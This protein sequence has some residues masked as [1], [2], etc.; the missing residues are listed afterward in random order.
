MK[1]RSGLEHG[2]IQSYDGTRHPKHLFAKVG[3]IMGVKNC[4]I[5][6]VNIYTLF[7][8]YVEKLLKTID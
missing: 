8:F 1:Q 4:A 7:I 6:I 2:T 5:M 3:A